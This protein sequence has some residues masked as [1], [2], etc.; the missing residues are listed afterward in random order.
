[1]NLILSKFR[2]FLLLSSLFL[3]ILLAFTFTLLEDEKS[4]WILS[5]YCLLFVMRVVRVV[6]YHLFY[7]H[8][9]A[10]NTYSA[11]A[12]VYNMWSTYI[13]I[14]NHNAILINE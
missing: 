11:E 2:R 4:D 6:A 14:E 10:Q 1:M 7:V 3:S 9:T 13:R 8:K 5:A 12:N